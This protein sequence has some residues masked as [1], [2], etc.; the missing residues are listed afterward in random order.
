M[1]YRNWDKW[2]NITYA[3]KQ[4][5]KQNKTHKAETVPPHWKLAR[6]LLTEL[7]SSKTKLWANFIKPISPISSISRFSPQLWWI[8]NH[9][10]FSNSIWLSE[11]EI[12]KSRTRRQ[13]RSNTTWGVSIRSIRSSRA[14]QIKLL[15][16]EQDFPRTNIN[17][18]SNLH[19]LENNTKKKTKYKMGPS[20]ATYPVHYWA[21][22]LW[23]KIQ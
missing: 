2:T 23:H 6:A 18:Q 12:W 22:L 21:F 19:W 4:I 1:L 7:S 11:R 17:F 3:Y 13:W 10:E 5:K 9:I 20:W 8:V 16:W 15:K 14:N